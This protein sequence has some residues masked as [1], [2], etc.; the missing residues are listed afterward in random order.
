M[1]PPQLA[2]SPPWRK[3]RTH[4]PVLADTDQYS[5]C[6][7]LARCTASTSACSHAALD[8]EN[9]PL[10]KEAPEE[11]AAS[12]PGCLLP[13]HFALGWAGQVADA[14][15]RGEPPAVPGK[16][17]GSCAS[18]RRAPLMVRSQACSPQLI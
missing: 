13:P 9:W 7:S 12:L 15:P 8:W 11:G 14:F 5:A 18:L 4:S 1:S 10:F 16:S 17:Y 2:P 3:T 6:I